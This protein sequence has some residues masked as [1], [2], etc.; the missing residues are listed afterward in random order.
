MIKQII[1]YLLGG[2][3]LILPFIALAIL[4]HFL[5]DK[6]SE[7]FS[8]TSSGILLVPIIIGLI[9]LGFAKSYFGIK[10]FAQFESYFFRLPII[11]SLYKAIKD[12]TSA[13]VGAENKFSEPVLV[14]FAGDIYKIGFITNKENEHLKKNL[15][16][17]EEI[18]YSVYF[19]LS[20]SLSGDLFLVPKENIE[21][22]NKSAK[23]AMQIIVS[24]GLI[25]GI[26]HV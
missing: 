16:T 13:F 5:Y 2:L 3:G 18:L 19:P 1:K 20:F 14:K 17:N 8:F 4:L 26:N 12:V 9:A 15:S 10:L 22:V 21:P 6:I 25:K 11:G 23:E 7:Y 24:G